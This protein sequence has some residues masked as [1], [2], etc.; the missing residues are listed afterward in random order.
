MAA[1]QINPGDVIGYWTI[2]SIDRSN[3]KRPRCSVKCKC[4]SVRDILLDTVRRGSS[5]SC[6]CLANEMLKT[7]GMTKHPLYKTW[8]NMM[9]RC[10]NAENKDYKRYG[11]REITVCDHWHNPANFIADVGA[12]PEPELELDRI[13]NDKGYERGNVHWTTRLKNMRNTSRV[14]RVRYM[15]EVRPSAEVAEVLGQTP[16]SFIRKVRAGNVQGVELVDK[17]GQQ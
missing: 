10:H 14:L 15:G 13:D 17:K 6:G 8:L 5:K 2:L 1:K 11:G 9:Q 16:K 3:T 7:H 4:G 12:R